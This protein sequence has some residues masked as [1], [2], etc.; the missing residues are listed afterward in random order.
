[1]EIEYVRVKELEVDEKLILSGITEKFASKLDRETKNAYLIVNVKKQ[2]KPDGRP[3]YEVNVRVDSHSVIAGAVA[4]DYD[5]RK[6]LHKA[7]EKLF[8]EVKHKFK[9]EGKYKRESFKKSGGLKSG[10]A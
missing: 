5:L 7:Y 4:N 9:T 8:S 2:S 10:V 3:R 1:M 6:A